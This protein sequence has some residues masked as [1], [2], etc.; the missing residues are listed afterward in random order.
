MSTI[1]FGS[2]NKSTGTSLGLISG[3]D[4]TSLIDSILESRTNSITQT[5]DKITANTD[6]VSAIGEMRTLL[7]RLKTTGNFLRAPTGSQ[8]ASSDFFRYTLAT[9]SSSTSTAASTYLSVTSQPGAT[10]NSYSIA[11]IERAISHQIRKDGFTSKTASVV[12]NASVTDNYQVSLGT[13]TGSVLNATT[14]IT[15]TNDVKGSKASIDVTFGSQ[16]VFDAADSITFGATTL[17][18][19]GTG[20]NDID[21]S[22][23]TTVAQKVAAIATR[24]NA[25]TTGEESRYTYT[26]SGSVL[27]VTR[28]VAGSNSEVDTSLTIDAN[29][30]NTDTTQTVKIGSQ[31]AAN[32][33]ASG[34]INILGT[35]G[36]QGTTARSAVLEMTFGSQNEFDAEDEITF[37]ST[38]LTFGGT[39][40][41]DIDLSSASSLD[42]KLDAIVAYMN[43]VG[44]GVEST[45]T[46]SRTSTGVIT[47]TQDTTGT[48]ASTG[49]D[50]NVSA[51]FS[52][53]T[54]DTTQTVAIG[55]NY[56]N[57]GS[58]SGSVGYSNSL[59]S[60]SVSENGVDG[61]AAASKASINIVFNNNEFDASDS[62]VFGSTDLRFGGGGGSADIVV[63]ASLN[64]TLQNIVKYMN[65]LTSGS[66]AGYNYT[67]NGTNTITITREIYGSNADVGTNL[68]ID[69]NFSNGGTTNT[70]AI[71]SQAAANNPA[72]G[73]LNTLGTDGVSQTA[74]ST[75]MTT[76]TSTLS[77]AITLQTPTYIAGTSTADS[78]T[79]NVVE[80]KATVGGVTYTSRPVVLDGG[81]INGTGTGANGLGNQIAAGTV[82][83][84]VKDTDGDTT[85]GTKDVAFQLVVGDAAT[86]ADSAGAATYAT[87][88]DT[89]LNTTNSITITQNPT[90]P[91]FRAGTFTLGGVEITL[92]EGDNLLNIKSKINSVSAASGVSADIIQISENNFS[93]V[94]RAV[95]TGADN[96]ILEYSDGDAGDGVS[97]TLQ[98]GLDNVTFTQVQAGSDA[99]FT[100]NGQTITRSSN[101]ISDVVDKV[102]FSLLSDTP[103]SSPP[104]LTVTIGENT[105][106]IKNGI[107][108]FLTAYN[109]LKFFISEQTERDE[110]GD[111]V[112]TALLG[113]ERILRDVITAIDAEL[114]RTISGITN[115]NA[116][117]LF[118]IGIDTFDFPGDSETPATSDIFV[119]D[120]DKFNAAFAANFEAV[121]NIFAH[122]FSSNSANL[123]IFSHSNKTTQTDY[124][125][126]ID[127]SRASGDQVRVLDATT[128]DFLFNATLNTQRR[129]ITGLAGTGL[130]GAVFIYTGDG[131]DSITVHASRGVA[132][133]VYNLLD[134]FLSDDGLIQS[135]IDSFLNTNDRLQE[136]VDDDNERLEAERKILIDRFTQVEAIVSSANSTLQFLA[137]QTAASNNNQ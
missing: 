95:D 83:T 101:V 58:V 135:S 2:F 137:S 120:E 86:I 70:I 74:I 62:L 25:I 124:I 5:S 114:S 16:N 94:L 49:N 102:T 47:I 27:T 51:D 119:I 108:D 66:E 82:I 6:K 48:I 7:D 118:A 39:G 34:D 10:L 134:G 117:T 59:V 1:N 93:L 121:R 29:F 99:S 72:S 73:T 45:Y 9:L 69:A 127:T 84:F 42:D 8:N 87:S 98:F 44:S 67:T 130:E 36:N 19:G 78:F 113:D 91:P 122:N 56:H 79:P 115:G 26:A 57:N 22:G 123:S 12:G 80:F 50:M 43:T 88:I 37:G 20:G 76:H 68:T 41:S 92:A 71:G 38:T 105:D 116:A 77:G 24:M 3:L 132:D 33:P 11:N 125:L 40:D 21:I 17:T 103:D 106:L 46:Y 52:N 32:N 112:E 131:T 65:D 15:F 109:D 100:L 111:L 30:S 85:E 28:D 96:K 54:D 35:D 128:Q 104:T 31:A 63:G 23:A 55:R 136:R 107:N 4:S 89:W 90:V 60:G 133:S 129:T 64:E 75:A 126:D 18:F 13:V 110:N 53:G 14:P 61:Y 81:D 97:G